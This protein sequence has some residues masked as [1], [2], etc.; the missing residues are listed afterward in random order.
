M[1]KFNFL[2]KIVE[3][4]GVGFHFSGKKNSPTIKNRSEIRN[5][6]VGSVQ[7]ANNISN[8]IK[9]FSGSE[10]HISDLEIKILR[11]LY[12]KYKKG[13][14]P[15]LDLRTLHG[16]LGIP[17]GSYVGP[18]NDSRFLKIEGSDYV[19]KDAGIRFMDSFLRKNKPEIDVSS[20][21]ISGG[22]RGQEITGLRLV[23]NGAASAIG[24]RC[25]ICADGLQKINIG[26]IERINPN[27]ESRN[28]LGFNYSNTPLSQELLKHLKIICEYKNKDGFNFASGRTL[29]QEK[30]ADGN[31]NISGHRGDYFEI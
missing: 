17:D 25:F 27:E 18:L 16:E 9:N 14:Y 1:F 23:N 8:E 13:Q 22:P 3:K 12:A 19:I 6:T 15:R 20:L 10:E 26:N 24:I 21:A 7:Q 4:F 11:K 29:S 30:R 2:E 28:S 31:Y 5:S